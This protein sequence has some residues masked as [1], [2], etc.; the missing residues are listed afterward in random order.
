MKDLIVQTITT[1]CAIGLCLALFQTLV[2][3][4]A[5]WSGEAERALKAKLDAESCPGTEYTLINDVTYC[6]YQGRWVKPKDYK[7]LIK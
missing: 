7:R 3:L 1:V 5:E 6:E 2:P 4:Y